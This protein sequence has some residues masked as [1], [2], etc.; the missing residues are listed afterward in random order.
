MPTASSA[1]AALETFWREQLKGAATKQLRIQEAIIAA[2][3]DPNTGSADGAVVVS[4]DRLAQISERD[5]HLEAEGAGT[6]LRVYVADA[7]GNEVKPDPDPSIFGAQDPPHHY[8][9]PDPEV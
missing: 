9:T 7:N 1:H 2:I 5:L 4:L 6:S 8:Q 3:L